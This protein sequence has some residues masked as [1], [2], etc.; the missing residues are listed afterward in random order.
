MFDL[1]VWAQSA[2]HFTEA[3]NNDVSVLVMQ[4]FRTIF[5]SRLTETSSIFSNA[6]AIPAIPIW[7]VV[8]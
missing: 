5:L 8:I 2:N 7:I 1:N 3:S 6:I 4:S